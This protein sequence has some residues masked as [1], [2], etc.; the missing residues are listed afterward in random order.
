MGNGFNK[1]QALKAV[2]K[3]DGTQYYKDSYCNARGHI[4]FNNDRVKAEILRI[5]Q[6]TKAISKLTVDIVLQDLDDG[7]A[8]AKTKEDLN[9][10]ARFC[11]LR[12]KYLAMY[13]D[14]HVDASD[15]KPPVL[16]DTEREQ[17]RTDAIKLTGGK[18]A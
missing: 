13:T 10:I 12:G 7:L 4:L 8:L 11:E 9:A 3:D 18:V 16:T 2:V 1:T 15:H 14:R 17:L 6:A 5:Q